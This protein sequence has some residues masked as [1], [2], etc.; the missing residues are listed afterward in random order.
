MY[1]KN[2]DDQHSVVTVITAL[3]TTQPSYYQLID[4]KSDE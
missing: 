3:V 4:L 1:L 2:S